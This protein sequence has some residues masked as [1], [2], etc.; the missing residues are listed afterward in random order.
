MLFIEVIIRACRDSVGDNRFKLKEGRFRLKI[1]KTF[2]TV[3][4][5]RHWNRLP[6]EAVDTPSLE[7]LKAMLDGGLNNSGLV[8]DVSAHG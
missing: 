5:V 6:R 3:K 8:K 1:R 2:F 7:V 4:V